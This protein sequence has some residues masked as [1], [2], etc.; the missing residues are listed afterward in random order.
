MTMTARKL[1]VNSY[2]DIT[3]KSDEKNDDVSDSVIE[4]AEENGEK[5]DSTLADD[6]ANTTTSET[7]KPLITDGILP[8]DV[9]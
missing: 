1:E 4:N 5:T 2:E 9:D 8:N 7:E 3:V 6:K